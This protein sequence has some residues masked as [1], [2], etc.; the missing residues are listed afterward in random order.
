MLLS[1]L[2]FF[3][4]RKKD[5]LYTSVLISITVYSIL[6]LWLIVSQ[7]PLKHPNIL[8]ESYTRYFLIFFIFLV[9]LLANFIENLDKKYIKILLSSTLIILFV[10]SAF[11]IIIPNW[12]N[13]EKSNTI[14]NEILL[15]TNKDSIIILGYSDKFLFPYRNTISL[16]NF[17]EDNSINYD[18]FFQE[19][20]KKEGDIFLYLNDFKNENELILKFEEK[21][22][23]LSLIDKSI[24]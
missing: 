23:D 9:V 19:L 3:K 8:H 22:Y 11:P 21:G 2:S 6:F 13:I 18:N 10:T 24:N 4:L 7:Y 14:A 20:N 16:F 5:T 12:E 17:E 1:F 15:K